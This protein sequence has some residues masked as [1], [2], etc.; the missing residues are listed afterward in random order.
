MGLTD[1]LRPV[2]A[3]YLLNLGKKEDWTNENCLAATIAFLGVNGYIQYEPFRSIAYSV[4]LDLT[5]KG[6]YDAESL[7]PYEKDCLDGIV[8]NNSR[9]ILYN[10]NNL[11]FDKLLVD[12]G[13]LRPEQAKLWLLFKYTKYFSTEK[14]GQALNELDDLKKQTTVSSENSEYL[15]AMRYAFPSLGLNQEYLEYARKIISNVLLLNATI[16]CPSV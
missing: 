15:Q 14:Y 6:R 9:F 1:D 12:K 3:L 10:T 16:A 2:E 13:I 5:D 4:D 8:M 11:D 7:R